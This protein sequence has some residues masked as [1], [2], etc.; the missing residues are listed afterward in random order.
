MNA[1]L[2]R[3]PTETAECSYDVFCMKCGRV[4]DACLGSW[5]DCITDSPTLV[6]PQCGQCFCDAAPA[7][8]AN[9][10]E[11]APA[12]LWQRRLHNFSTERGE[13]PTRL[14]NPIRRPLV[15]VADDD[16]DTRRIAYRVLEGLG[17]GVLLAE[18]GEIAYQLAKMRRPDLI[19]TDQ[20]MPHM[21]GKHLSLTIKG[22][23]Q[24][25]DIKVIVMS[26]L[27]KKES[28]RIEVLRDFLADD[29]LTKPIT[30]DRLG[31]VLASW[32]APASAVLVAG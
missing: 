19:L 28:Q 7:V 32:L 10:W 22:D 3:A 20:M 1:N 4:Y 14:G 15:L 6:C 30:F 24:T 12:A 27:Y 18:D 9:F 2:R 29:Y 21:D 26:G 25:R 11:A 16:P 23:P 17:Y 5:C 8:R 31:E 13:P